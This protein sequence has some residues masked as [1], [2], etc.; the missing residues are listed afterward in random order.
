MRLSTFALSMEC[1]KVDEVNE[2]NTQKNQR[3][4]N[5]GLWFFVINLEYARLLQCVVSNRNC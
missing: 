4:L 5:R 2:K 3:A 1:N